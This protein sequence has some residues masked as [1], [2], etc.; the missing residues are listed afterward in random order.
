MSNKGVFVEIPINIDQIIKKLTIRQK[1][2]IVKKL[3][4][5][6]RRKRWGAFLQRIEKKAQRNPIS[7]NEI[8]REAKDT[9]EELYG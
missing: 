4:R 9:R 1:I 7:W 5:E 3:E 8:T 6:T 2:E